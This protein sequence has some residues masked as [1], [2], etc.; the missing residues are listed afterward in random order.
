MMEPNWISVLPPVI[1]ILLAIWT[2][3]VYLSLFAG[4]YFGWTI[5]SDWNPLSGLVMAVDACIRVFEDAGNTKVI[6]FSALIGA[7]LTLTQRS[8]GVTGFVNLIVGRSWVKNRR[9]AQLMSA[10]IGCSVFIESSITSLIVGAVSRPIFDRFKI[11]REKLAYICDSTSAPICI[12]IPLNAWGAYIMGLLAKEDIEQPITVLIAAIPLNF[13]AISAAILVFVLIITRKDFGPMKKAEQRAYEE[14]KP[15]RDGSQPMVSN[16]VIE[17]E[18]K[19][20]IA[21]QASNMLIPVITMI[22]MMPV[23]MFITG[24]GDFTA[25]S[26]STSVLWAVLS[27][28]I[29]A[30]G[31]YLF[32]GLM[33]PR[34]ITDLILKGIS[35]LMPLAILMMFAFAIGNVTR[36]LKTGIYVAQIAE[37]FLNSALIPFILFAVSCFIAFSTGTSWGTFAIMIP[38]AVPLASAL[39]ISLPLTVAAVLGGGVFGDHC[40]PISDSTMVASM[41]SASDHI[42]HV[43][44]QLPY[45]FTAASVASIFYLGAGFLF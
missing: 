31:L 33:K 43:R 6:I 4:I 17:I 42:D 18:A 28:I 9:T 44:T 37:I 26:G 16:E 1:A 23:S 5:I 34:E 21:P 8:G 39:D 41:A 29:V 3:E 40:S 12:L 25:G 2:R 14:G 11:S 30:S 19:T 7:L 32:K 27:S 38:I 36:E 24:N 22:I 15:L 10:I 45:A 35:G 13:Y 20:S